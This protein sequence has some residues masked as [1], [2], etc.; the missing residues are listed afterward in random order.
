VCPSRPA[1]L[2]SLARVQEQPEE[3]VEVM[4]LGDDQV[5]SYEL[6]K[7]IEGNMHKLTEEKL[8]LWR[9]YGGTRL[10]TQAASIP[11]RVRTIVSYCEEDAKASAHM[12]KKLRYVTKVCRDNPAIDAAGIWT[13]L[14]AHG[15][16]C[17]VQKEVGVGLAYSM[18]TGTTK[19]DQQTQ[20]LDAILVRQLYTLRE[21]VVEELYM[22]S[23]TSRNTH[24]MTSYR[25]LCCHLVG[26][27]EIPDPHRS[28]CTNDP[29]M[30]S[31]GQFYTR[32]SP[33]FLV[34]YV[35]RAANEKRGGNLPY[36]PLVE[37][38]TEHSLL[39]DEYEF[40]E[41]VFDMDTG[42]LKRK[43]IK[44]FLFKSGFLSHPLGHAYVWLDGQRRSQEDSKQKAEEEMPEPL[45]L[46][47]QVSED[48]KMPNMVRQRSREA[49]QEHDNY[50]MDAAFRDMILEAGEQ[51]LGLEP[52]F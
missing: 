44:F 25:N 30:E 32:Y 27:A 29:T 37:F 18:L 22:K 45:S 12:K 47:R 51:G 4:D 2:Q 1:T 10:F 15:S 14:A 33:D 24:P 16:M 21:N 36:D 40:L 39:E 23:N 50:D 17:N 31:V 8:A 48:P 35:L 9:S 19:E 7:M 46:V 28:V 13:L 42:K 52:D 5:T 34:D 43:W 49:I 6:N 11:V 38:F 20:T 26:L 3:L 41:Q